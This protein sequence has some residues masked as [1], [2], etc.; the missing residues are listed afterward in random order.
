[1]LEIMYPNILRNSACDMLYS[2]IPTV[3]SRHDILMATLR[4]F[5]SAMRPYSRNPT[6]DSVYGKI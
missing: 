4:P 1:M 2:T 3:Y 6:K 5:L